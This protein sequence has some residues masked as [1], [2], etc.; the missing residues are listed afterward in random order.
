[1]FGTEFIKV[2][3]ELY[4]DAI[5]E[6]CK[7]FDEHNITGYKIKNNK[8][9]FSVQFSPFNYCNNQSFLK[10]GFISNRDYTESA[11]NA[12]IAVISNDKYETFYKIAEYDTVIGHL[13]PIEVLCWLIEV[14]SDNFKIYPDN[15]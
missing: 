11:I 2:V 15:H 13:D 8:Y 5:I 4:P 3:K 7:F 14:F 12:E 6:N 1:M 9:I 10:P